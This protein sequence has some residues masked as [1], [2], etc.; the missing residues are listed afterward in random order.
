MPS[1][2]LYDQP[3][4][5]IL[6]FLLIGISDPLESDSFL[7]CDGRAQRR[8]RFGFEVCQNQ[9]ENSIHGNHTKLNRNHTK[10]LVLIS[11]DFVDRALVYFLIRLLTKTVCRFALPL[12]S[13]DCTTNSDRAVAP[14]L[15]CRQ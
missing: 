13:K 8:W 14:N 11:C 15:E 12:D 6:M 5:P 7:E 3:A 9:N 2:S 10:N 4:G 1:Q